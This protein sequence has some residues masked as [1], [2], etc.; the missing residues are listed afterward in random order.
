M[1]N[2][3]QPEVSISNRRAELIRLVADARYT[4][5]MALGTPS[6]AQAKVNMD[7]A[8]ELLIENEYDEREGR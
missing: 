8:A 4:W 5:R 3:T 7:R 2:Q 1:T 6:E